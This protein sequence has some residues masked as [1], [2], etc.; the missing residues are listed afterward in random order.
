M[1]PALP[2]ALVASLIASSASAAPQFPYGPT[3]RSNPPQ[4]Q[5]PLAPPPASSDWTRVRAIAPRSPI[6]VTAVGLGDQDHQYFV[7]ASDRTLTLLVLGDLPRS[8]RRLVV[9]L[10]GSHPEIFMGPGKWMEFVDGKVRVNP[11]GVFMGKRK[12]ADLSDIAKTIDAGEVA[13]VWAE[14][15]LEKRP[16]DIESPSPIVAGTFA[17]ALYGTIAVC[18]DKCGPAALIPILGAPII[19]GIVAARR[20]PHA[21]RVIYRVR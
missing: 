17:A 14:V 16:H 2:L 15:A 8:A 21:M 10:A 13:E 7:S 19:A 18:K 1:K 9:G 3:P 6:R 4:Q 20:T 5:Y 12:V 11:D